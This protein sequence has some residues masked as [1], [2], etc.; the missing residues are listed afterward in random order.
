[1]KSRLFLGSIFLYLFSA[2]FAQ[3]PQGFN[4]QAIARDGSNNII[5]NQVMPVRI[6]LQTLLSGGTVLYQETHSVTTNQFGMMT[7]V[8]GSG[9]PVFG[10]F[11]TINWQTQSVFI[12]TEIQYP[13]PGYT[14]MGTTQ[15]WAVPYS[16]LAK[17]LE[18]PLKKLGVNGTTTNLD[19]ALFEV[20]NNIGQT[21]F[22]VYNEGVRV[23]VDDGAKGAKGGFAIG[24]FGTAKA[25]SQEYFRITRDS[26]RIYVAPQAKGI[27]GGFA[28]GDI[29]AV[30]G[31]IDNYV[32]LTANNNFIGQKAGLRITTG[33]LNSFIGNSAGMNTTTGG[34][35]SFL[36][37][38]AGRENIGGNANTFVGN[39]AG[40]LFT[41]GV[42][43]V[44]M[45][46]QSGYNFLNGNY[47]IF[48]G[49]VAGAGFQFPVGATGG[50]NNVAIGTG[51]GFRLATG[52]N[53]VFLG[54]LTGVFNTSGNSNVFLGFKSG[55]SNSTGAQNVYVGENSGYYN[56]TG[57]QNVFIGLES[58]K[59]NTI[60]GANA[61][62]GWN[63]GLNNSQG[64]NNA[65]FGL[66]AGY[67]N[68]TASYNTFLGFSA[69]VANQTGASN[70]YIGS[71]AGHS[72]QSGTMNVAIGESA[73]YSALTGNY[74]T[75]IGDEAGYNLTGG[76]GNVFIG[77]GAGANESTVSNRLYI[78]NSAADKNNALIY[79]EFDNNVL[80]LNGSVGIGK[81]TPLTRL[82]IQ[83]GNWDVNNGQG[84]FRIA[85]G[86]FSFNIGLADAGGGMGDVRL[87]AKGVGGT[88]HLI[89][90]GGGADVL[91]VTSNS[92]LPWTNGTIPLGATGNKWSVVYSANGTIQTSDAR[93]KTNI[94]DLGYGL[95]EILKLKPVSFTWKD[96]NSNKIRLGLLA[97]DVEKV[98][99][100]V[101]DKGTDPEKTLGINYSELVPVLIKSIQ[102]Q[103]QLI[104]SQ[105]ER[106]NDQQKRI[107]EL[108]KAVSSILEGRK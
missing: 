32:S 47:N 74:N 27:K 101:V 84:D 57:S 99:D 29:G 36:G 28:I 59:N 53:N 14:D 104:D 20:K 1:M 43:N 55:Y 95:E 21:I 40:Q 46:V 73:A 107:E 103:E 90:G 52:N 62:L 76:S 44:F 78:E 39:L 34:N 72:N 70:T 50:Q 81:S 61:F 82:D 15:L 7:F 86:A 9:T 108:E 13:G 89:L 71:N 12:R 85:S 8:L 30:K 4:Y 100:E 56:S 11:S 5:P 102:Q 6:T 94:S 68:T 87:N 23:Y 51:S 17:D 19:E 98:I 35:N 65:F 80:A 93:L 24:G 96:D 25:P 22:A 2:V 83:G 16:M 45:G 10:T 54:N 38:E 97:Q 58:G 63:S 60:G 92:V 67:S 18:G 3:V 106:I 41:S 91:L 105:K 42:G 37:Y 26:A 31:Q 75:I 64:S 49:S 33:R 88:N 66:A 48:I 77:T 69:G 79:G